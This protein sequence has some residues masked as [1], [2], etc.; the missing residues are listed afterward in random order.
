MIYLVTG[1]LPCNKE[2]GFGRYISELLSTNLYDAVIC[3]YSLKDEISIYGNF[4]TIG[5]DDN[6]FYSE[7]EKVMKNNLVEGDILHFPANVIVPVSIP[8]YI[9]VV[10]TLHDITPLLFYKGKK[11]C[12]VYSVIGKAMETDEWE[13]NISYALQRADKVVVVSKNTKR[14]ILNHFEVSEDRVD[15][16]YNGIDNTFTAYPECKTKELKKARKLDK[17]ICIMAIMG[18]AH[19]NIKRLILAFCLLL[20]FEKRRKSLKLI[21][22]GKIN[23]KRRLLAMILRKHVIL[24]GR[25]SE[26]ELVEWYNIS[27]LFVFISLYEGFGFPL[28]EAMACGARVLCSN[29][30]SLA[31][32]ACGYAEMVNPQKV[33]E[34]TKKIHSLIGE[35]YNPIEQMKY[36]HNFT[37]IKTQKKYINVFQKL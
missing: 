32:I 6:T 31:E 36:A 8:H 3:F 28:L 16:I 19:K 1:F 26:Q 35:K 24:T 9:K 7:F 17:S 4:E 12:G 2:Y 30:S 33:V 20:L 34:I 14:D 23:R 25:I 21:L 5:L 22:V 15:V 27:D 29:T 11:N 13:E 10:F 37:W 18:G